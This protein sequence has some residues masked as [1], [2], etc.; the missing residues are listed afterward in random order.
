MTER[1]DA[2]EVREPIAAADALTLGRRV[3]ERR[4]ALGL[5]LEQLAEAVKRAPS[6]LSAIENGRREPSLPVLRALAHALHCAVDDLL[7]DEAPS[8]R[9]ALEIAV[10]RAQQSN[11]FSSLN[12]EPIR[13]SK[14]TPDE[15]LR[16][17]LAL[18]N[19]IE[20]L[21][22]ERASTPEEARRANTQ[23]RSEMRVQSNYYSELE[24]KASELIENTDYSGGPVSQ[25][26]ISSIAHRLGYTLHYVSDLP[27]A[28][29]S[30]IDRRNKRVY[31]SAHSLSR[32][33][34]TPILRALAS[35]VCEHT[36]PKSYA[37]YL[38]QRVQANYLAGAVL[39][40]EAVTTSYL[41]DA[42]KQREISIE[43]LR[44]AFGVSYEMAA[45][46]FT[47]LATK[48]LDLPVHFMKVHQ[49]GTLIK[50]YE[51]DGVK[52]PS[53]PLG[54]LEG[55]MVCRRWTARTVF[56]QPDR[57]NPWYQY[58]DMV[59]GATYWCTS[60]VEEAKE[61]QYSVSV[62]VPFDAVKWF[63]GRETTERTQSFC[64][65]DS[66]CRKGPD[67]LTSKWAQDAWP[68]AATPTSLLAAL[69]TGTF[70]GVEP[71]EVYEFLES[72]DTLT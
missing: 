38:T 48:H 22:K 72:H 17:V 66:C 25:Q 44:D 9:A 50:A 16:A 41:A 60:R 14:T 28:T 18:H 43:D 67:Q 59:N 62:G 53:D 23:L 58:T 31:L 45:H 6:Q 20:R 19:E 29:R 7:I 27:H 64:P 36:E 65:D 39:M 47:N 61:G 42:K 51:N 2:S 55:S 70:P 5:K 15:T 63:R 46:R 33:A 4:L 11:V 57:F 10:T 8:E 52:F 21:H 34:R 68:E 3:R 30:V 40:P 13:V 56:D 69:P 24:L 71:Q 12:I 49:S 54:N 26:L 32:D 35:I 1:N 37:D